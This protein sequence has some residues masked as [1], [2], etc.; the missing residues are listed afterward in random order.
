MKEEP[1]VEEET[2]RPGVEFVPGLILRIQV[3]G[4]RFYSNLL[5]FMPS[6]AL[7]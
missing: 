3:Q 4:G 5:K 6:A 2:K 7:H 1:K